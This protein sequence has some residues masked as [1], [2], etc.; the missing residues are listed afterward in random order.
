MAKYRLYKLK[1]DNRQ[2]FA[3]EEFEARSDDRAIQRVEAY[4]GGE[5]ME[6]WSDR[7]RV[8][9]FAPLAPHT[10][11]PRPLVHSYC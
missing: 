11:R 8:K 5:A 9:K 3:H 7:R 1:N 2:I 4:W 10:A 6:L